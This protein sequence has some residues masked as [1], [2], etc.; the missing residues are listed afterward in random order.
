MS[1]QIINFYKSVK[2]FKWAKD[3]NS[4]C[5]EEETCVTNK[6]LKDAQSYW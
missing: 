5:T 6:T 1:I 4:H 2:I 3:I